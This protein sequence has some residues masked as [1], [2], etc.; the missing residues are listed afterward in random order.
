M[1]EQPTDYSLATM[2]QGLARLAIRYRI[3]VIAVALALY[4]T[5][6][7]I[8]SDVFEVLRPGGFDDPTSESQVARVRLEKELMTGGV[9]LVALYRAQEGTVE[10]VEAW[11]RVLAALARVE[12]DPQVQS[13]VSYYTTGAPWLV[14]KD[15]SRT[16]VVIGLSGDDVAKAEA[17]ERLKPMLRAEGMDTTFGGYTQVFRAVNATIE[18]D[19]TRAEMIAFPITAVLLVIIFRSIVSA[20][21]P[22]LLGGL[23]IVLALATLRILA[24]ITET[25]VFAANVVTVLG[26]GLAIDY[27]LFILNRY[28]EEAPKRGVGWALVKSVTTTGRAVAF[29][30]LTVAASLLGLFAFPHMVLRSIAVGGIAVTLTAVVLA[31][32]ALPALI[33]VLGPRVDALRVPLLPPPA[34]D[35]DEKSFWHRVAYGVMRR[36]FI[37]SAGVVALLL[38]LGAPFLRF[39]PSLAEARTLPKSAEARRVLEDLEAHFTP[40]QT[41]SHDVVLTMQ[42]ADDP[43]ELAAVRAFVQR[44]ARIEGFA[45]VDSVFTSMPGLSPDEATQLALVPR[46]RRD[47]SLSP[48]VDLFLRGRTMRVSLVSVH[49]P[50]SAEALAQVAALRAAAPPPG[51]DVVVGGQSAWL[52]DLRA[53]LQARTPIMVIGIGVVMFVVLFLVF[54]SVILPLKAIAMNLLSLT[55]SF[56]AIV[57]VFQDG[58]FESLLGYQSLGTSDV[59]LPVLMFAIVFGLSMDYEVLLL[60]RVREEYVRTGDNSLSVARGLART[61]RL[62]TSAAALMVVVFSAFASSEVMLLKTL[63]FGMAL[64]IALDATVVRSLLVPATMRL[65]GDLNWWAPAPL[66]RL[67]R[68]VGMGDLEGESRPPEG[69]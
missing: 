21:L 13:V 66:M 58:R 24:M 57:W 41:T 29:S 55:A 56:G 69:L 38:L 39:N 32:T 63:A 25:S 31:L 3:A 61:G 37:V 60:S 12:K 40:H 14:S 45:R 67:W 8:G 51:V 35:D 62:I 23:S 2:L 28:R 49:D 15:K 19:L 64:A 34:D 50:S 42:R 9:D 54:G 68:K 44:L 22:L 30:G 16:F 47:P 65:L 11:G 53:S 36:P 59:S 18:E 20:L 48:L 10:D 1:T 33:A 6:V 7:W 46:E 52:A 17:A 43:A 27:S 5:A 4:P 26:L